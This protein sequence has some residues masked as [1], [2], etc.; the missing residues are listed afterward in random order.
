MDR[1]LHMAQSVAL[2]RSMYIRHSRGGVGGSASWRF[3]VLIGKYD[4][5]RGI[6][7]AEAAGYFRCSKPYVSKMIKELAAEGLIEDRPDDKD[8]RSRYLVCSDKGNEVL[9]EM[10]GEY[11]AITKR[12]HDGL[13]ER[14]SLSFV[15]LLDEAIAILEREN[16]EPR[17]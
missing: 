8:A 5:G 3:L 17:D 12:L 7:P 15:K 10:M 11:V 6:K 16:E 13:G 2:F 1:L 4:S 14:K 9:R